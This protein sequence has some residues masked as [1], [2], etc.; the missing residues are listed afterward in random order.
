MCIDPKIWIRKDEEHFSIEQVLDRIISISDDAFDFWQS[1]RGWAPDSAAN[2][3]EI[4]RL[5]W[6]KDLTYCLKIWLNRQSPLIQGEILLARTN[7]GTLVEGWLKLF[8]CVYYEDYMNDEE[9]FRK[10]SGKLIDPN[11][12]KF[13]GLKDFSNGKLW[14][15]DDDWFKWVDDIQDKRNAIHAF[16]H[17]DI[18]NELDL[19]KDIRKFYDF[20]LLINGRLPYPY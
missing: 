18:G 1:P 12:I 16:N 7:L 3:L 15:K 6:L 2:L 20:I 11:K 14:G 10:K 17:R 13:E 4:A 19:H 5:D 8:Y 9:A